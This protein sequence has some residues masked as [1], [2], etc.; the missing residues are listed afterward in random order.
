MTH[1]K[2][3]TREELAARVAQDIPEGWYV[4]LGIGIPTLVGNYIP[5]GRE[6]VLHSENGIVG[7]GPAPKPEDLNPWLVNAS[8]QHVTLV[9]GARLSRLPGPRVVTARHV[10][11]DTD[12][13]GRDSL[14]RIARMVTRDSGALYVQMRNGPT[15]R[16]PERPGGSVAQFLSQVQDLG[17]ELEHRE[18]LV[19]GSANHDIT[20]LVIRWHRRT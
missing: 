14:L 19:E 3:W 4:N 17:G 16:D 2:P 8:R 5:A 6:V 18:D 12:A 10:V 20:R 9:T 7:M 13:T 15:R 11:D 1:W